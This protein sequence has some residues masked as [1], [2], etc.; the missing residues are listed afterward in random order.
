[1]QM[2]IGQGDMLVTPLQVADFVAAIGNG[3]TLYRPQII[4]KIVSIDGTVIQEFKP[5]V[6]RQLPVSKETLAALK[7]GMEM[8]I[9]E[10]RG[11]AYR[12][13]YYTR[14]PIFGKTGTASTSVQD[15]HSWF[16]G[17]TDAN[18]TYKP[19]IA[20]AVVAEYAGDGSKYAA[21]I[22]RRV[23]E[24]YFNGTVENTLPWEQSVYLTYTPTPEGQGTPA[25]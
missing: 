12:V 6:R 3:G 18:S 10:P 22:F 2:G 16:T 24:A 14:F 8:V 21:P 17:F 1:V 15:P 19:D 7:T 23:V 25:P 5:E 4:E 9:R 20:V 11:T 13:F